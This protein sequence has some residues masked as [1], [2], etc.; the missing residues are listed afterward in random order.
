MMNHFTINSCFKGDYLS[1]LMSNNEDFYN[2]NKINSQ[3]EN[4]LST[5]QGMRNILIIDD[6]SVLRETLG[7]ILKERE[8]NVIIA[9]DGEE[10]IENT[11]N[12]HIDIAL[13]DIKLPGIDGVETYKILKESH[14]D[15]IA[16][17]M[18][19]YPVTDLIDK[20]L[21]CGVLSCIHKPFNIEETIELI[22]EIFNELKN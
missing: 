1:Y 11:K 20:A 10:A 22:E 4:R 3:K 17:M 12:I 14:S 13:I 8:Y 21:D 7:L 2:K 9:K 19:A 5:K 18:T 15:M 6:E 16:V